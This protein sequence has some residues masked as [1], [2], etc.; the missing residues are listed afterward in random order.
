MYYSLHIGDGKVTAKST[1]F[2]MLMHCST[3]GYVV[4][5]DGKVKFIIEKNIELHSPTVCLPLKSKK[6]SYK[7]T[8]QDDFVMS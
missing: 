1:A 4:F 3:V 6:M 5:G 8:T 2:T 7:S